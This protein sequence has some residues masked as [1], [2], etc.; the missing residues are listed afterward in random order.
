[1]PAKLYLGDVVRR[2]DIAIE[3]V[4]DDPEDKAA[5]RQIESRAAI[6]D[7]S[8][9]VATFA[10]LYVFLI[11]MV[12]I[13]LYLLLIAQSVPPETQRWSQ[14]MLTAILSGGVSF[15]VGRKLGG[16]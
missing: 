15:L 12:L 11:I 16:K 6:A 2:G 8:K 7:L 1:M 3:L 14:S 9:D 13:S 4:E 10:A 5:R